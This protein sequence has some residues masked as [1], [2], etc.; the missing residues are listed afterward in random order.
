[1]E[2]NEMSMSFKQRTW[3]ALVRGTGYF[4]MIGCIGASAKVL[5]MWMNSRVPQFSI[6]EYSVKV[7]L[8]CW[9]TLVLVCL[10]DESDKRK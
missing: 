8:L 5:A 3:R 4:V 9:L 10:W 2:R 6:D 1:M 7:L